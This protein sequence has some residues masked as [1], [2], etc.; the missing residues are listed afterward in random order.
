MRLV[1]SFI[2]LVLPSGAFRTPPLQFNSFLVPQFFIYF[3]PPPSPI[4]RHPFP[5]PELLL[6][7]ELSDYALHRLHW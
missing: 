1:L 7:S 2:L 3:S 6:I 5:T 4:H